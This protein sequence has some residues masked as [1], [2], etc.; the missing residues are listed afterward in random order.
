MPVLTPLQKAIYGTLSVL[1]LSFW[2]IVGF[3]FANHNESYVIVAQLK[4]MSLAD[5]TLGHIYPVANFRPLG[6]AVAWLG[7]HLGGGSI[8]G[9]ELFNYAGAALA[10]LMVFIA[11]R[12]RR[13]FA[14]VALLAGGVL[15]SGYIY[16]FHLHGVFYSPMLLFM[17]LL[18]F[19]ET[20]P[21]T[22]PLLLGVSIAGLCASFFHPYALPIYLAAIAG[23]L[24]ERPEELRPHR[25]ILAVGGVIAFALLIIMVVLPRHESVMTGAEMTSGLVASY[26]MVEVNTAV[27]I[28]AAVLAILTG[29]SLPGSQGRRLL[30]GLLALA[31]S[32]GAVA[33]GVPV[34]FVWIAVALVKVLL[35][36]KWWLVFVIGGTALFPAPAATGSP[37]YAVFVILAC[38]GTVALGWDGGERLFGWVADLA[39]ALAIAAT[40]VVLILLRSGT[41]LPVISRIAHPVLAEREKTA[42]LEEI[43]QWLIRSPYVQ[44]EPVFIRASANPREASDAIDRTF[45]TPTNQEYLSKY[46]RV[47]RPGDAAP[48]RI[49]LLGFG[50]EGA[51]GGTQIFETIGPHAGP[52]R[53]FLPAEP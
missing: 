36:K 44:Y 13:V 8:A 21:V 16:L 2:F 20:R 5:A 25:R 28:V 23:F 26:R 47:M 53:V 39:G 9:V 12:E 40:V 37:T 49:V 51:N 6:Q 15:F 42:Q 1:G 52:A 31:L 3:P 41:E 29:L 4:G 7:Y 17:A 35:M 48:G 24:L 14:L 33:L 18:F 34:I 22:R 45:R 32:A 38:A 43:T 30:G 11:L 50:G 19:W 46:M 27:S 10:W